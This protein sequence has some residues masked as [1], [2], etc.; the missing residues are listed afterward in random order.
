[1]KKSK[2]CDLDF[3]G[4]PWRIRTVDT[5]RQRLVLYPAELMVR[6]LV[7]DGI[8]PYFYSNCKA[9]AQKCDSLSLFFVPLFSTVESAYKSL[10]RRFSTTLLADGVLVVPIR[11]R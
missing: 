6:I 10:S 11:S 2:S 3:F 5:K 7:C 8:I 9:F 4:T 1:M